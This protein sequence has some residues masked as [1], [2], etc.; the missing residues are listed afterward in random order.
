MAQSQHIFVVYRQ[1]Y[2]WYKQVT[3]NAERQC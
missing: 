2:G 3:C 1:V